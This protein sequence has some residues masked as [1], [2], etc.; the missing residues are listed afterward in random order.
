MSAF[1]TVARV[2]HTGFPYMGIVV[3]KGGFE[4]ISGNPEVD[5]DEFQ[6][7]EALIERYVSATSLD[8]EKLIMDDYKAASTAGLTGQNVSVDGWTEQKNRSAAKKEVKN[9]LKTARDNYVSPVTKDYQGHLIEA[10]EEARATG[11]TF[12]DPESGEENIDA[13]DIIR[14]LMN[15]IDP[16]GPNGWR[17]KHLLEEHAKTN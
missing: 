10:V 2:E 6:S 5:E 11:S 3:F 12:D 17:I 8:P 16:N 15:N 9:L 4:F 13:A 7:E 1:Y 14:T